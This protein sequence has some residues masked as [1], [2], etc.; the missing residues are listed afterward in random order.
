MK[1]QIFSSKIILLTC[2]A[3]LSILFSCKKESEI[4]NQLSPSLSS[5]PKNISPDSFLVAP[6]KSIFLWQ[7]DK[8]MCSNTEGVFYFKG[9]VYDT[10][11]YMTR[12]PIPFGDFN[13]SNKSIPH[14]TKDENYK[15]KDND[16]D[17]LDHQYSGSMMN[18]SL[19]KNSSKKVYDTSI[20]ILE[21]CEVECPQTECL[22]P[23]ACLPIETNFNS[24]FAAVEVSGSLDGE[25][26]RI[27]N[28]RI[29]STG[30]EEGLNQVCLEN[31]T[32][33]FNG[34]DLV[35]VEIVRAKY[36]YVPGSNGQM[37]KLTS[38]DIQSGTFKLCQ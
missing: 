25:K 15:Y 35:E 28:R 8:Q 4:D 7:T 32:N 3:L 31:L 12:E 19:E 24:D 11:D 34:G 23:S 20:K 29:L 22:D 37:H 1:R 18:V 10:M 9:F 26:G 38:L 13:L 30:G 6:G 36:Y 16:R 33:S 14:G 17:T 5:T 21:A 27:S 2:L